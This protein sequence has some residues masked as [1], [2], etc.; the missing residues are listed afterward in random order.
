LASYA[1]QLGS[2]YGA[3]RVK[4]MGQIHHLATM[5]MVRAGIKLDDPTSYEDED[6][7]VF[8]CKPQ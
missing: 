3:T 1:D 2:Q 8:E 6:L 5:E 7:G 4:L